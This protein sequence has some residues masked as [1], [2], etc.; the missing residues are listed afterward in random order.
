[1]AANGVGHLLRPC[2]Q[3]QT[4]DV[5]V[6][7]FADFVAHLARAFDHGQGVEMGPRLGGALQVLG[8]VN[9]P[10]LAPLN[11]RRGCW[12]WRTPQSSRALGVQSHLLGILHT[13]WRPSGA[14]GGGWI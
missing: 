9:E 13:I 6:G 11:A 2:T 5:V 10:A 7:V 3:G 12:C 14:G 4:A 8:H 1:M